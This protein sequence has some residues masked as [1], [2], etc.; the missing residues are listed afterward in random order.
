MS[1]VTNMFIKLTDVK[2][3]LGL[4]KKPKKAR[5]EVKGIEPVKGFK[6]RKNKEGKITQEAIAKVKGVKAIPARKAIPGEQTIHIIGKSF[7]IL[8]EIKARMEDQG[9]IVV[10]DI[11]KLDY[12]GYTHRIDYVAETVIPIRTA[13]EKTKSNNHYN[14]VGFGF[15]KK[16]N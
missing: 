1:N 6:E 2:L 9:L 10:K 4:Y 15:Q 16:K 8:K 13:F 7:S 3:I 5:T 11:Y 14:K 12:K